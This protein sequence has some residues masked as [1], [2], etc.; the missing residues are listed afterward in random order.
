MHIICYSRLFSSQACRLPTKVIKKVLT[1]SIEINN[2]FFLYFFPIYWPGPGSQ[3]SIRQERIR[4]FKG[5]YLL[6]HI[7]CALN[8]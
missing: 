1:G 6:I 8:N 7:H 5:N 3:M 2:I 4:P